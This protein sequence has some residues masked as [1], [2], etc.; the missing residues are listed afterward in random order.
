MTATT[1]PVRL[2]RVM[3]AAGGKV[4]GW[5]GGSRTGCG[6]LMPETWWEVK[7]AID[8]TPCLEAD[9]TTKLLGAIYGMEAKGDVRSR[10]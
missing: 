5:T 2:H 4:H 8:C 3:I 7:T 9:V 1:R 10:H 6:R